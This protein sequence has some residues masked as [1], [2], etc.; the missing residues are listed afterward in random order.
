MNLIDR[1]A[2]QTLSLA[3]EVAQ[4]SSSC[5]GVLDA[6]STFLFGESCVDNAHA[7]KEEN[8]YRKV[9]PKAKAK[10]QGL[11]QPSDK[12][13]VLQKTLSNAVFRHQRQELV[14]TAFIQGNYERARELVLKDYELDLAVRFGKDNKSILEIAH[15]RK[16]YS[17]EGYLVHKIAKLPLRKVQELLDKDLFSYCSEDD[18]QE[19]LFSIACQ[20]KDPLVQQTILKSPHFNPNHADRFGSLLYKAVSPGRMAE[21]KLL[22]DLPEVDIDKGSIYGIKPFDIAVEMYGSDMKMLFITHPRLKQEEKDDFLRKAVEKVNL[23]AVVELLKRGARVNAQDSHGRTPLH[24]ICKD[25]N[26]NS[27][28]YSEYRLEIA[29]LLLQAGADPNIVDHDKQSPLYDASFIHWQPMMKLLVE[30]GA[31]PNLANYNKIVAIQY[32][33]SDRHS[34]LDEVKLLIEHGAKVEDALAQVERLLK[35]SDA[36]CPKVQKYL[37]EFRSSPQAPALK[38]SA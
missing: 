2:N 10:L 9:D 19:Y 22:L 25:R 26:N 17:L 15:D 11:S 1:A 8:P 35:R 4:S 32:A 33:V 24:F 34:S 18:K 37:S 31:N 29:K 23:E 28:G 12:G 13:A 16:W 38:R 7:V 3:R 27:K 20:A 6:V 36:I 14:Q 5:G 30:H 21:V